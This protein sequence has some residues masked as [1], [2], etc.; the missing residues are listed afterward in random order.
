MSEQA[1]KMVWAGSSL[2]MV[3]VIFTIIGIGGDTTYLILGLV[4]LASSGM[5]F[6]ATQGQSQKWKP[7]ETSGP[8]IRL[9]AITPAD[10]PFSEF[11]S[12]QGDELQ[13]RSNE[14]ATQRLFD[15]ELSHVEQCKLAYRFLIHTEN[16][17]SAVYPEMW[18]RIPGKG[19]FFS[20]G[21]DNQIKGTN[22]WMQVE[23]P[24][25]LEKGQVADLLHLNLVFE[26]KGTV[27]LKE[28]EVTSTPVV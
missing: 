26:G 1:N 6:V 13:V 12:W 10:A 11:A 9:R 3:G 21:V 24:F 5:G 16:L 15:V 2:F 28:I 27:H 14:A 19:E 17:T 20:R 18:C 7:P 4:F 23:I 22:D 25:Y 8:P